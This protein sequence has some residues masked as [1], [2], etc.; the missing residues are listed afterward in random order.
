M[1]YR[2]TYYQEVEGTVVGLKGTVDKRSAYWA[3]FLVLGKY[4][5]SCAHSKRT[6]ISEECGVPGDSLS[7]GRLHNGRDSVELCSKNRT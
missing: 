4:Q 2:V 3:H 5:M 7:E 6:R 1:S